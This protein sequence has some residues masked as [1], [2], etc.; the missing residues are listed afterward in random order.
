MLLVAEIV[1]FHDVEHTRLQGLAFQ[2]T[3]KLAILSETNERAME[4]RIGGGS[5]EGLPP[6]RRDGQDYAAAAAA[7]AGKWQEFSFSQGRLGSSGGRTGYNAGVRFA[8]RDRTGQ[9]RTHGGQGSRYQTNAA[10]RGSHNMDGSRMVS[11]NRGIR[12]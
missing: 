8:P 5:L 9:A 11:L 6:R 12:A 2:L 1:V 10:A 3:E 4:S 7:G